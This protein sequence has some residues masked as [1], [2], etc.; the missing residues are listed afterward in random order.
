MKNMFSSGIYD[1]KVDAQGHEQFKKLP[2]FDPENVQTWFEVA[3]GEKDDPNKKKGKIYFEVFSKLVPKTAENFRVYCEGTRAWCY[4]YKDCIFH[5]LVP[6]KYVHGGDVDCHT[7]RGGLS[8]Y[9]KRYEDENVWLPH[10]HKGIL[11]NAVTKENDN[12]CQFLI[13]YGACPE[14][15]LHNTVFA[16]VIKNFEFV[17]DFEDVGQD[18]AGKPLKRIEI[19]GCGVLESDKKLKKEQCDSLWI[20]DQAPYKFTN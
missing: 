15:N 19:I 20:Y 11:T 2:T 6:E 1:E 9:G 5:R 3:I 16:R 13:T 14:L 4:S 7:G 12:S 17:E 18:S 8:I 10:T